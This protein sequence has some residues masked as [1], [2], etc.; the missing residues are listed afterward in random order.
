MQLLLREQ[1]HEHGVGSG[2]IHFLQ[3]TLARGESAQAPINFAYPAMFSVMCADLADGSALCEVA[4]IGRGSNC[5]YLFPSDIEM[6]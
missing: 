5:T 4:T 3:R 2:R 6:I 1:T